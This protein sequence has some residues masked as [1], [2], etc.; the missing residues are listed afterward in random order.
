MLLTTL[1]VTFLFACQ[2]CE[3][4]TKKSQSPEYGKGYKK[5]DLIFFKN[6]GPHLIQCIAESHH[7]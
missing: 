7:M 6:T 2:L 1:M 5:K 4:M 3:K